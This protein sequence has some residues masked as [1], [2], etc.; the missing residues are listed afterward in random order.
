MVVRQISLQILIIQSQG[1]TVACDNTNIYA[2]F[3]SGPYFRISVPQ[4][5]AV[6]M[7]VFDPHSGRTTYFYMLGGID[8]DP[9]LL[10]QDSV[11]GTIEATDGWFGIFYPLGNPYSAAIEDPMQALMMLVG[12]ASHPD[13]PNDSTPFRLQPSSPPQSG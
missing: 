3:P 5:L 2:Q 12:I 6:S 4:G 13:L 10:I 8:S 7:F 9:V 1:A 11:L